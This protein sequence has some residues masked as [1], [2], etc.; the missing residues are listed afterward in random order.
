MSDSRF[1]GDKEKRRDQ[2]I[3]DFNG[4]GKFHVLKEKLKKSVVRIVKDQFKNI[5][6]T[7]TSLE[8]NRSDKFYSELYGLLVTNMMTAFEEMIT[9]RRNQ[10]HADIIVPIE[11]QVTEKE[12]KISETTG[13]PVDSRLKRLANEYEFLGNLEK[14]EQFLKA[15]WEKDKRNLTILKDWQNFMLRH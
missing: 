5:R 13:E 3:T 12:Q 15:R 2:Y 1:L 6:K 4:S 11:N 7:T 10:F 9:Q 14:T 8:F